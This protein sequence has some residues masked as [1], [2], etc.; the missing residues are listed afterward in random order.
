MRHWKNQYH[1]QN[2][3]QKIQ[4]LKETTG[5]TDVAQGIPTGVT[6]GSAISALQEA[7]GKTSRA[8]NK[9]AYGAYKEVVNMVIELIRQHYDFPR[10]FRITGEDGQGEFVD[11]DNTNIKPQ[12][13]GE[14][15]GR[16]MG[17]RLPV[18]DIEVTA[19]KQNPYSKNGQNET[20]M[21]LYNMGVFNPEFGD[22]AVALVESMDFNQKQDVLNRIKGNSMLL[23]QNEM[24]KQQLFETAR[25]LDAE[26]GGNMAQDL[27]MA[28]GMDPGQ[29]IPQGDEEVSLDE[30]KD[31][32]F[33]Q[34]AREMAQESTQPQ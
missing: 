3:Q 17:Y 7:A 18:F 27:A 2:L 21:S 14:D 33:N 10:Q 5:N 12:H 15:F 11:Y 4:E 24:L 34:R 19:Q 13:Q 31:Y 1:I 25:Q 32:P 20:V 26:T 30:D 9:V 23:Q 22:Q 16:D 8:E 6:S 29:P 28:F